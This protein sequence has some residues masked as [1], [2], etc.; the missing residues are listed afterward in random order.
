[1]CAVSAQADLRSSL[2][3]KFAQ[4]LQDKAD[5]EHAEEE[6]KKTGSMEPATAEE[7]DQSKGKGP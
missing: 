6:K 3:G 7:L 1:M 4:R 2:Q 5:K